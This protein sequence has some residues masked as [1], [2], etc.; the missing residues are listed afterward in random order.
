VSRSIPENC[1]ERH[2]AA[3]RRGAGDFV[4]L[5]NRI[6]ILYR[7]RRV[8]ARGNIL[9]S[10]PSPS[11]VSAVERARALSPAARRLAFAVVAIAFA[12]ELLD[13]TIVNV[14]IPAIQSD[15]GANSA[16][17]QWMVAGYAMA[18]GVLLVTGGRLG[19]IAGYKTMFLVGVAGFTLSSIVCGMAWSAEILVLGRVLQGVSGALMAPQVL[20]L[21]QV[22][23][24]PHERISVLGV[25]G[26]LGGLA[27]IL[28]PIVGGFIISA[29]LW[30]LSWR[31]IFLINVPIG[32]IGLIAG[33]RVLP[34]GGSA[35]ALRLDVTGTALVALATAMLLLPVIEGHAK[36]WP[37]LGYGLMAAAAALALA[38]ARYFRWRDARDQ[39]A[40]IPPALFA[41]SSFTLGV[42]VMVLFQA[43]MAG[44]LLC[45]TL[46]LQRGLGFSALDTAL[47]HVP[48]AAGATFGI[49][50]LSRRLLGQV[51]PNLVAIG[52]ALMIVA[53]AGLAWVTP[54]AVTPYW[55][56]AIGVALLVA[57]LGMGLVSGPMPPITLSNVDPQHAGAAGGVVKAAQ[58]M[59]A[60]CGAGFIGAL[61]F[62]LGG[63]AGGAR[64]VQ[65]FTLV[66]ALII[67]ML[68]LVIV[69]VRRLPRNLRIFDS[70]AARP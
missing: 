66:L 59:G 4:P 19:D 68:G 38:S 37:A 44:L 13:G 56:A 65:A 25:F 18:F 41:E 26:I 17:V 42:M 46:T 49:G 29:D 21:A 12:M 22:M 11:R 5:E 35:K 58:Q 3:Q 20:A 63:E 24:A 6:Y 14:A 39:A 43:A 51:G 10:D 55:F 33:M 36:H 34:A 62:S 16:A 48:F 1:S 50:V 32:V 2:P 28:G 67:A 69:L 40:L 57:G 9:K 47:I 60:A 27:S 70:V 30:G 8:C 15:L 23:F 52:M 31:P 54:Q 45:F 61:Y 64:E 7:M 53:L